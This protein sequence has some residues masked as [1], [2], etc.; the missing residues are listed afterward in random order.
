MLIVVEFLF[1]VLFCKWLPSMISLCFVTIAKS[2]TPPSALSTRGGLHL[3][4]S[5]PIG[6][7]TGRGDWPC[8]AGH[9]PGL[10]ALK[11]EKRSCQARRSSPSPEPFLQWLCLTALPSHPC[12]MS[13]FRERLEPTGRQ[14]LV[15]PH[16]ALCLHGAAAL[17]L[18]GG[19]H[20]AA[21]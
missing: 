9:S 18:D 12:S 1:L 7:P 19:P 2:C 11:C 6:V 13:I 15:V 14:L 17:D 21:C 10:P 5:R 4:L 20:A 16:H 8:S 3:H